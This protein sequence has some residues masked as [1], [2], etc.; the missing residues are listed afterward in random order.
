M[1]RTVGPGKSIRP[2]QEQ[3]EHTENHEP[4]DGS[5]PCIFNGNY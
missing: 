1:T 4:S 5:W 2:D 3:S